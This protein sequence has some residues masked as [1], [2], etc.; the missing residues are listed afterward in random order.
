LTG[1][2]PTGKALVLIVL[3]MM[4]EVGEQGLEVAGA[5]GPDRD[6]R[7]LLVTVGPQVIG[8]RLGIGHGWPPWQC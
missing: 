3:L 6:A 4:V 2:C 1:G 5:E 8:V 7:R